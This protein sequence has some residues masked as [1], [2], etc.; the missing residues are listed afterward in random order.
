MGSF[1][2]HSR[3]QENKNIYNKHKNYCV[4]LLREAWRKFYSNLDA[5]KHFDTVKSLFSDKQVQTGKIA[6][7]KGDKINDDDKKLY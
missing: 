1:I 4:K 6:L 7:V 5:T 2:W 3:V